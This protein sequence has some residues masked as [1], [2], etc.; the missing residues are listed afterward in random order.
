MSRVGRKIARPTSVRRRT[1]RRRRRATVFASYSP[2]IIPTNACMSNVNLRPTS[3]NV[4]YHIYLLYTRPWLTINVNMKKYACVLFKIMSRHNN[5]QKS[6]IL[7]ES[8]IIKYYL[9]KKYIQKKNEFY[10]E[11]S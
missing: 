1:E 5:I 10:L 9:Y 11:K 6:I 4:R 2:H 3:T 7:A 8:I